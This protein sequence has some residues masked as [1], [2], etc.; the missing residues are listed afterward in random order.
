MILLSEDEMTKK[1]K[2]PVRNPTFTNCTILIFCVENKLDITQSEL[3]LLIKVGFCLLVKAGRV[4]LFHKD[5]SPAAFSAQS[6]TG[7]NS[8]E[9]FGGT[10][11]A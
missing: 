4:Q 2:K 9:V 10:H 1:K 7:C 5:Q 3:I 6:L 11:F 8:E